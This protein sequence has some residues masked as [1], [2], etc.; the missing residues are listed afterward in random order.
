MY[1]SC[2]LRYARSRAKKEG[3]SQN[4]QRR[5]KEKPLIIAKRESPSP[6]NGLPPYPVIRRSYPDSSF[7]T[8]SA[9]SPSGSDIYSHSGH[10][11]LDNITPSPS[12]PA[13]NV[14]F[15]HYAPGGVESRGTG[16]SGSTNFYSGPSPLANQAPVISSQE[17]SAP[18]QPPPPHHLPPLGQLAQYA[19]RMSPIG[20]NSSATM[21][22]ASYERERDLRELPPTPLSA[23]PRHNRRLIPTQP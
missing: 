5:R 16:Y 12:P 4:Q 20:L 2:G 9:G 10:H 21:A 1:R 7:S 6:T 17:S 23:E 19:D 15:V 13:P 18:S 14:N 3:P 22:P 11:L 8:S